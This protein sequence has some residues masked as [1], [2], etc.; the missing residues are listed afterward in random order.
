MR[1]FG[2]SEVKKNEKKLPN[3]RGW[4]GGWDAAED[5]ELEKQMGNLD[6]EDGASSE[7]TKMI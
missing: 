6:I 3:E 7:C 1:D 5:A 4:Y 2:F